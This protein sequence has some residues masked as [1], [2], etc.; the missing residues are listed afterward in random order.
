[1]AS[2]Q[3]Y[4]GDK[5]NA[6]APDP[7]RAGDTTQHWAGGGGPQ[8]SE[9]VSAEE[10][11]A[12]NFKEGRPKTAAELAAEKNTTTKTET[13]TPPTVT[14]PSTNSA[15]Y[16]ATQTA[17]GDYLGGWNETFKNWLMQ[18]MNNPS[19]YG[20]DLIKQGQAVLD[21]G[22]KRQWATGQKQVEEYF[23]SRGMTGS[24]LE[25]EAMKDLRAQMEE[26]YRKGSFDLGQAQVAAYQQQTSTVGNL[27]LGFGNNLTSQ[28]QN[29]LA[30]IHAQMSMALQKYGIDKA[31]ADAEASRQ[32]EKEMQDAGFEHS[33]NQF[34][35]QAILDY[36]G[37]ATGEQWDQYAAA[38][39]KD[40]AQQD[41]GFRP[42]DKTATPP[43]TPA[44]T[45]PAPTPSL[46][47][48]G[49]I[50]PQRVDHGIALT[51]QE[52]TEAEAAAATLRQTVMSLATRQSV[53]D[54]FAAKYGTSHAQQALGQ[55]PTS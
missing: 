52:K 43:A 6:D 51:T 29:A 50:T 12:W 53:W 27:G 47:P 13:K 44:G 11:A 16:H 31:S 15:D 37:N 30:D 1:M 48:Q 46:A 8:Y 22:I 18:Q 26:Q 35:K 9:G 42:A 19:P 17:A 41:L 55:R 32:L 25:A 23:A 38:Y 33:D 14:P 7:Y 49:G 20:T 5:A 21:D 39:G 40:A 45:P 24:S 28:Q 54:A 2:L 36:G 34:K 3:V 4:G 10:A